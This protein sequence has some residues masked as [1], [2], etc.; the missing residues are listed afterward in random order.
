MELATILD[1]L[2][3]GSLWLIPLGKTVKFILEFKAHPQTSSGRPI[4]LHENNSRLDEKVEQEKIFLNEGTKLTKVKIVEEHNPQVGCALGSYRGLKKPLI[5]IAPGLDE[6]SHPLFFW[7]YKRTSFLLFSESLVISQL[8]SVLGSISIVGL[9]GWIYQFSFFA[10]LMSILWASKALDYITQWILDG[11][12]DTYATARS[13]LEELKEARIFLKA[14]LAISIKNLHPY[15]L[16][17]WLKKRALLA[18]IAK[19]EQAIGQEHLIDN[20]EKLSLLESFLEKNYEEE[21]KFIEA[22]KMKVLRWI[23]ADED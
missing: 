22:K 6:V 23:D 14:E 18:R 11:K 7:I 1:Y 5:V 2:L 16:S 13:S 3:Y 19:I 10:A 9:L 21:Q 15:S 12:A 8:L 20:H 4:S 17:G